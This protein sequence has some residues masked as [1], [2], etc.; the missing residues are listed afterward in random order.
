[1]IGVRAPSRSCATPSSIDWAMASAVPPVSGNGAKYACW[2]S[3]MYA[4]V[5]NALILQSPTNS[6]L[7]ED[8]PASIRLMIGM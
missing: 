1:M 6:S 2:R 5:A 3:A 7:P 8:S 4:R